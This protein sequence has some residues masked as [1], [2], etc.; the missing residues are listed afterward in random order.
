MRKAVPKA[1]S[2]EMPLAPI[3]E[4]TLHD[5]DAEDVIQH[6][7][8]EQQ[9]EEERLERAAQDPGSDSTFGR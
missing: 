5:K 7:Q 2:F 8:K 6:A 9:A 4:S 1:V 3:E